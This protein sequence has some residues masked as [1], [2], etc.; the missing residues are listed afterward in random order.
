M[1]V[2]TQV[3]RNEYTGNGATT[4]YDFTFR[5]L[6]KSHLLVQTLDTSESIVTLTLGTDYTVT[7][8]NRYNG[9]KVVLTSALPA[10][11]K[12]SI[13]RSTPVTQEASIRN[14]GGFFPEIHEDAFDKLT[15]LVQQAYGWWS[16]LSLRKPS[17]LANYYDALNNRIRNL[18][19]PSLAQDAATKSYVDSSDIDLQQQITSNFNRS[20]RVPD[21]YISQLP[22]AQDR[23]WKGLGFDGAG[24]PKL[25]DPAGTGLWGY[26][27]A[28]G[29]FEQGSLLTQRFE[30]L[31]W[32]S[33]DEYWRWDGVMPKVVLP[34]ST[35]AT[36]GGTGK[37]KWIDVTDATLR[38]NLGSSELPGAALVALK[39]GNVNDALHYQTPFMHGGADDYDS[40]TQTG[41]DNYEPLRDAIDAALADGSRLVIVDGG[42]YFIDLTVD[43]RTPLNLGGSN[44]TPTN[45]SEGAIGV[46][47]VC[48]GRT[49]FIVKFPSERSACFVSSGGSGT[50]TKRSIRGAHVIAH[51]TTK[52]WGLPFV[53]E[54]ACISSNYDCEATETFATICLHNNLE[55]QF[56]EKNKFYNFR[57]HNCKVGILYKITDGDNSF[58]GNEFIGTQM[59]IF[60]DEDTTSNSG[61]GI[62]FEVAEGKRA[63]AYF[64]KFD[65]RM[66]GGAGAKAIDLLLAT[67]DYSECDITVEDDCILRSQDDSWFHCHGKFSNYNG[68]T[69]LDC[70]VAPRLS[71]PANFIFD[72][73][74]SMRALG[75]FTYTGMTDWYPQTFDIN[76]SDRMLDGCYPDIKRVRSTIGNINTLAF[77]NW[78]SDTAG[79]RFMSVPSGGRTQDA[80]TKWVLSTD[81][82]VISSRTDAGVMYQDVYTGST[83]TRARIYHKP[84]AFGPGTHN[85]M[86]CGEASQ[87]W[88]QVFATNGTISPSDGRLKCDKQE[89]SENQI[90]AFYFIGALKTSIWRWIKRV[91]EEG[92]EAR[93][94]VG[95][96]AQEV[97]Q[98]YEHYCGEGSWRQCGV[99]GYDEW[100]E[101]PEEWQDIPARE[102]IIETDEDGK[103]RVIQEAAA[104]T[105]ILV[106]EYR[107]A[108]SE[109][110][111]RKDEL[112]W[113]VTHATRI[114]NDRAMKAA[115]IE[116]PRA[117]D[118]LSALV[119]SN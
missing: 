105:R 26:V 67:V 93:Y 95:P 76:N 92:D 5:I 97:I 108:G 88:T 113:A 18:R 82:S 17:W 28:I 91:D 31:L 98:I 53:W 118:E 33:T 85:A 6:D 115:G 32:E 52:G 41:T 21:S 42:R 74:S 104:A 68:S 13:E 65:I 3:S 59:N 20:L 19:D 90:L 7:G 111:L 36:A 2:S 27:P 70:P 50:K 78:D 71:V 43:G 77:I 56:T 107:A 62:S 101:Q 84:T 69:T 44:F 12:I 87:A 66:F 24:Q 64:Q 48:R 114:V 55:G 16:G 112:L 34:G 38:S 25:Q 63:H 23:A 37:G 54:G 86:S 14:Q 81:G 96:I 100:A 45:T 106:R 119:R 22:S 89:M 75:N 83:S 9:G 29:S 99:F 46:E 60:I 110:K 51:P 11:Y 79:F 94:H 30:V 47:L 72:N 39:H 80:K 15:M 58:H 117:P 40:V 109:Y 8:V 116:L 1:T 73:A 10:G 61:S 102:E 103:T 4:Q 35:P 49:E 57:D